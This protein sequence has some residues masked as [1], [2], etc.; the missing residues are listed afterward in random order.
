MLFVLLLIK[1]TGS[2]MLKYNPFTTVLLF[3]V[4]V[5]VF[6]V[7]VSSQL[8]IRALKFSGAHTDYGKD[9]T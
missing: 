8:Y 5:F 1:I 6:V 2:S 4:F 7:D 3:F 9:Y